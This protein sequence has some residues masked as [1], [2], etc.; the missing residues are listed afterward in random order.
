MDVE[1]QDVFPKLYAAEGSSGTWAMQTVKCQVGGYTP[2]DY[3]SWKHWRDT[4]EDVL[5]V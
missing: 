4:L 1:A 2:G 3:W 5:H